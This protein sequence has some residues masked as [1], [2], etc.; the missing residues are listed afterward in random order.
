MTE[1]FFI[2]EFNHYFNH[3]FYEHFVDI[4]CINHV[5]VNLQSI[6]NIGPLFCDTNALNFY[7]Q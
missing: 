4:N 3:F 1:W 5:T 2:C 6:I 7:T